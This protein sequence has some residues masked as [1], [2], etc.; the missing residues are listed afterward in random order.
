MNKIIAIIAALGLAACTGSPPPPP[1]WEMAV[2]SDK[3]LGT[4]SSYITLG[5]SGLKIAYSPDGDWAHVI[6]PFKI[7]RDFASQYY[8]CIFTIRAEG[9]PVIY[10]GARCTDDGGASPIGYPGAPDIGLAPGGTT[11]VQF[12]EILRGL[13]GKKVYFGF[14]GETG[15]EVV[16]MT[17]PVVFEPAPTK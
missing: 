9:E 8:G 3:A 6:P 4:E 2:S 1:L 7:K 16:E 5:N 11:P 15:K 10:I 12:I 13:S 17:M 14:D